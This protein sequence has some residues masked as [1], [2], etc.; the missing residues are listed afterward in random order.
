[1]AEKTSQMQFEN[2]DSYSEA[3]EKGI[4]PQND[5]SPYPAETDED[6]EAPIAR[7]V[8][9]DAIPEKY[10]MS[11]KFLGSVFSIILLAISLYINF[12][13]P[14]SAHSGSQQKH[15][16]TVSSPLYY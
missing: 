16:P 6:V 14:V 11:Y 15:A 3:N 9:L 10:W 5:H 2:A 7:G 1:M 13:L 12:A 8:D 4:A